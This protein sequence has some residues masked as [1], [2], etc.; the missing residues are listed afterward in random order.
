MS[1]PLESPAKSP[2]G[3]RRRDFGAIAI[4]YLAASSAGALTIALMSDAHPLAR[5]LA[6][7]L[8][9]TLTLF[10]FARYHRNS[11][12]FDASWS[13]IPIAI[14]AYFLA[15]YGVTARGVL[16]AIVVSI[17]GVRLTYNWARSFPGLHH[18][19]FRYRD[20]KGRAG[21]LAPLVD[22]FAIHLFPSAIV[23]VSLIPAWLAIA[24]GAS[25]VTALAI[26][27]AALSLLGVAIEAIADRQLYEFNQQKAPGDLL[28]SGLFARLRHPNYL[29][30][31][32]FWWGLAF[33]GASAAPA[34]IWSYAGALSMSLMFAFYSIPAL[35]RRSLER[36]PGYAEYMKATPALLPKLKR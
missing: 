10:A 21:K 33:I 23:F 32:L 8:A 16:V 4:A 12:V 14:V 35:D 26:F 2:E 7:D 3:H 5:I 1:A 20:L 18:E 19:D 31:I 15:A 34:S 13:V 25:G 36:R 22:L 9:A 27:G 6:A 29:G 11:S 17:W 30:E 24:S 28:D